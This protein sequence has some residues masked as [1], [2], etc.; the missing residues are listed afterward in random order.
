M[1]FIIYE[2][3]VCLLVALCG[4]LLA[5]NHP[6][7]E[8]IVAAALSC[9]TTLRDEFGKEHDHFLLV[10][11]DNVRRYLPL[12]N[13]RVRVH[14]DDSAFD[15]FTRVIAAHVAGCRVTVSAPTKSPAVSLLEEL[16]ESWAGAIEFVEETDEQLAAAIRAGQTDRVRFAVDRP[17]DS[18]R[19][20]KSV[21]PRSPHPPGRKG[22]E[23]VQRKRAPGKT[24]GSRRYA[25]ARR[26]CH[27]PSVG[28]PSPRF[29]FRLLWHLSRP[30]N[31][32]QPRRLPWATH[33]VSKSL[34]ETVTS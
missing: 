5:K 13:V 10:G 8:H 26:D 33:G 1:L 29:P 18:I 23:K 20:W 12:E 14:A 16:T 6:E 32:Q 30:R 15:I 4:G 19:D 28:R 25:G 27:W 9:E 7:A 2:Y 34:V 17:M 3:A 24:P 21:F 11:Q 22:K 31:A